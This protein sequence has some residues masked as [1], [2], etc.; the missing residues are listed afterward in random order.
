MVDVVFNYDL[1]LELIDEKY[2][3]RTL[4]GKEA[5][6]CREAKVNFDKFRRIVECK[7]HYFLSDEIYRMKKVLNIEDTDLYFLNVKEA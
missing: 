7:R 2:E 3:G 5:K 4:S 1:L 6:M